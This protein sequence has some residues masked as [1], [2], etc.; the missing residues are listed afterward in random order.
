[1]AHINLLLWREQ[2]REERK[3]DFFVMLFGS[4]VMSVLIMLLVHLSM[5]SRIDTQLEH[6][7]LLTTEIKILGE[8]I[9]KINQMK[10]LKA[11]LIARM[12]IIQELQTNR[13]QV[14]HI[15]DDLVKVL[16]KGVH[17][18]E[19]IR[20]GNIVTLSGFAESNTNISSLMRNINKSSWLERPILS[21]IKTEDKNGKRKSEFRLNSVVMSVTN[22]L[23]KR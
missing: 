6:N 11:A 14:V 18:F 10:K 5:A 4:G 17:I 21:E 12:A 20:K 23:R 15:F 9:S 3:K 7:T 22:A 16:P 2:L 19:I 1:M 13:P 8:K